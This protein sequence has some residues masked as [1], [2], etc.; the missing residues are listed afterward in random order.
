MGVSIL[1][2]PDQEI[3]VKYKLTPEWLAVLKELQKRR[4]ALGENANW[5]PLWERVEEIAL[6]YYMQKENRSLTAK[7]LGISEKTLERL[8]KAVEVD[9]QV[10]VYDPS[11]KAVVKLDVKPEDLIKLIQKPSENVEELLEKY[12]KLKE[13]KIL[14]QFTVI[15]DFINNPV[16]IK[17][18]SRK[19]HYNIAQ[20]QETLNAIAEILMYLKANREKYRVPLNPDLWTKEHEI[21]LVRAIEDLCREKG[22]VTEKKLLACRASYFMRI[23]RIER[24][25]RIGLFDGMVGRVLKRVE[26]RMEFMSLEQYKKLYDHYVKSVDN[27]YRA[28]FEIM[29]LHLLLGSR[30]GYGSV[31][32][33]I[34]YEMNGTHEKLKSIDLD[35]EIIETSLIGVKWSNVIF[36]QDNDIMVKVYE[37]KTGETWS[38]NSCWIGEWFVKILRERYE[39]AKQHNI[40]SVVK[41]ILMYYNINATT[42]TSFE[43]WYQART[44][45]YTK[46][47]IGVELTPHRIR[48]SHISILY[49][50]GVPLEL[51]AYKTG[52]GVGWADLSTAVEFYWRLTSQ[53]IK[54]YVDRAREKISKTLYA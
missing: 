41:T 40:K 24:Y 32:S 38:L 44:K 17:Q 49:E 11:R 14:T 34:Y 26:P 15:R 18:K 13:K 45:A 3:A 25:Y 16:R 27:D 9:H 8:N 4:E 48:A 54:E 36:T 19:T 52:F 35:D 28:W 47:I 20:V 5:R 33:K 46:R 31:E 21:E 37:S 2:L 7:L 51:S 30:E 23:R 42:I 6:A 39:Y 10:P 43:K 50:L 29:S 12:E 1:R 53:R 22:Y